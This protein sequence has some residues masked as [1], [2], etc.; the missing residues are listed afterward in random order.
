MV[1]GGSPLA[2]AT[3]AGANPDAG[4]VAAASMEKPVPKPKQLIG[5]LLPLSGRAK[6]LGERAQMGITQAGEELSKEPLYDKAFF[7]KWAPQA[8]AEQEKYKAAVSEKVASEPPPGIVFRDSG[9]KPEKARAAV[10]EL[11]EKEGVV[12]IIGP[13]LAAESK[14]AAEEADKLGVPLV[15]LTPRHDIT[16]I[17]KMSYRHFK[18][19]RHEAWAVA[20][21]AVHVDR[22]ER[23]AVVHSDTNYGRSVARLFPDFVRDFQS[24]G[25]NE[26]LRGKPVV[27]FSF[28][29]NATDHRALARALKAARVDAIYFPDAPKA[30]A[31]IL[32]FLAKERLPF[33][34][35]LK[36][37]SRVRPL[38]LLG[39]DSWN[40]MDVV[41][42]GGN[43]V[44]GA[45][46]A[47]PFSPDGPDTF[48]TRFKSRWGVVSTH[49]E[50]FAYGAYRL[51]HWAANR[52]NARDAAG[53]VA[54]L[55]SDPT[56]FP[57]DLV[58]RTNCQHMHEPRGLDCPSSL[59]KVTNGQLISMGDNSP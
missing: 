41:A 33:A 45:V 32:P 20:R 12:A 29:S 5:V 37:K 16:T 48:S 47:T 28:A 38:L 7:E 13:M 17:G 44:E 14:A 26:A 18:T 57:D 1:D 23:I 53:F 19:A 30:A 4:A 35:T 31:P 56:S 27:A 11:V 9:G 46:V 3:D 54:A 51:L 49:I 21:Y 50:R 24:L 39:G 58:A 42:L 25:G 34:A 55:N 6:D 40:S 22:R 59:V 10:R 52:A 15:T 36:A 2:R 8:V 43:L